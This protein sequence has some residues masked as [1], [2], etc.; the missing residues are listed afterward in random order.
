MLQGT[1]A[2]TKT[3]D[4]LCQEDGKPFSCAYDV[5]A[6]VRF[7]EVC[8]VSHGENGVGYRPVSISDGSWRLRAYVPAAD[9]PGEPPKSGEEYWVRL[10][11]QQD[12]QGL[13]RFVVWP[14]ARKG[15]AVATVLHE[16]G[17][18]E[19]VSY[20]DLFRLRALYQGLTVGSYR[21][22]L[23]HVLRDIDFT[24]TF[25]TIP[26]SKSCHHTSQGGLLTH[27]VQVAE[28]VKAILAGIGV[29]GVVLEATMLTGLFHDVGKIVLDQEGPAHAC[30]FRDHERLI[31][32]ALR[33][34]LLALQN[35]DQQAYHALMQ[36][37]RGY[38]HG[39]SY[40]VPA[41]EVV[42]TVD[43]VSAWHDHDKSSDEP[44]W[45]NWRKGCG[46]NYYWV[47]R[48]RQAG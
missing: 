48:P 14:A 43:R 37:I 3:L 11:A 1:T 7:T 38:V 36:V 39:D 31:E 28:G 23:G 35:E 13:T 30:R 29:E 9:W 12:H 41:G 46:D 8:P 18:L 34:P 24:R 6:V 17:G 33:A 42:R 19:G 47:P 10:Q 5:E 26:A 2:L 20:E 27:S 25:L 22:F 32:E 45:K 44:E 21:S 16:V 4:S 15:S 40:A